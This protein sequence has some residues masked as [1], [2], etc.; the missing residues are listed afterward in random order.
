M[1]WLTYFG[2]TH[3]LINKCA[4][5][6]EADASGLLFFVHLSGRQA[7]IPIQINLGG[8]Y[9]QVVHWKE[10]KRYATKNSLEPM[11]GWM[12]SSYDIV[13][14]NPVILTSQKGGNKSQVM[15][16]FY[17][18][19]EQNIGR[20]ALVRFDVALCAFKWWVI[21]FRLLGAKKSPQVLDIYKWF[22]QAT[23]FRLVN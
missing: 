16:G 18:K 21:H 7:E 5:S 8:F 11:L 1:V 6:K 17:F 13:F 2:F 14:F 9:H 19:V 10:G 22:L 15:V 12:L 4:K 3:L 20:F 23:H